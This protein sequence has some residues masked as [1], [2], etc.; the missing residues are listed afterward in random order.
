MTTNFGWKKKMFSSFDWS[1]T[2]CCLQ[3][4]CNFFGEQWEQVMCY[5]LSQLLIIF[6]LNYYFEI[7]IDVY[8]L[9]LDGL[10]YDTWCNINFPRGTLIEFFQIK[11]K[12]TF[13]YVGWT[14][15]LSTYIATYPSRLN[16]C[17]NRTYL[18]I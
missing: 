14:K 16:T 13:R 8:F 3:L 10:D 7:S 17:L 1:Y 2:Y 6:F 4:K 12:S 18:P 11:F 15:Y 5:H 9:C